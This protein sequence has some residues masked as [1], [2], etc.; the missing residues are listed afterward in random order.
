MIRE[1]CEIEAVWP[2]G[3]KG[4]VRPHRNVGRRHPRRHA[5]RDQAA[6]GFQPAI[7]RQQ[8]GTKQIL[9]DADRA[10]PFRYDDV[11]A[12]GQDRVLNRRFDHADHM[13]KTVEP[14]EIACEPRDRRALDGV[15]ASSARLRGEE[16]EDS[17]ARAHVEHDVAGRDARCDGPVEGLGSCRVPH[18]ETVRE[19]SRVVH[20]PWSPHSARACVL[21]P[22]F[23]STRRRCYH[24][25]PYGS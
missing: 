17:A 16:A 11:D 20:W 8:H 15:D 19:S 4:H 6:A 5:R 23:R 18:Q 25:W 14:R 1:R 3:E 24:P 10:E 2:A 13:R 9:V 21:L 22:A 12:L 7:A